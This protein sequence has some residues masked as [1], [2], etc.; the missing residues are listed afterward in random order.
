MRTRRLALGRYR[1][2]ISRAALFAVAV[3]AVACQKEPNQAPL[4]RAAAPPERGPQKANSGFNPLSVAIASIGKTKNRDAAVPPQC[5]TKTDGVSNPCWTCH[6]LS[7]GLN[8]MAD[9]RLQE[10]YSFSEPALTNRWSN[11]FVDNRESIAQ[12]SDD[13]ILKWVREDNYKPLKVAL[14]E[15]AGYQGYIPDLDFERG[16]DAEGFARDGSGWRAIRFKPFPGT[17]FP[18]NGSADDVFVR[19]PR[20]FRRDAAGAE[21]RAIYRAN[22]SILEAVVIADPTVKP[23]QWQHPVEP[24]DE[25]ALG[26]DLDGDGRLATC[27]LIRGLPK[28]Y[29]GGAAAVSVNAGFHPPGTEYL[30]SVRYL[31]PDSPTLHSPRMKELRYS[32]K[33]DELDRWATIRAYEKE[34]NEKEENKLPVYPGSPEVGY[35]NAFGW[36]L[37]G[38]IED[39]RGRLRAHA[40]AVLTSRRAGPGAPRPRASSGSAERPASRAGPA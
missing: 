33:A 21:S 26:V 40:G 8:G 37:Q 23:D 17:F 34:R 18:T 15:Q 9:W 2:V 7:R 11:L 5:Y 24:L 32:R 3:S 36:Q 16:F 10:E 30:H 12:I 31:D 4:V 38:F 1:S 39:E 28:H 25:R 6:T 14:R 27:E 29:L 19:L 20:E 13:E 22:L 35:V